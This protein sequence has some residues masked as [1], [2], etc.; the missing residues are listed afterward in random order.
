MAD[1]RISVLVKFPPALLARVAAHAEK[2]KA[3][4]MAAILALIERGLDGGAPEP[5]PQPSPAPASPRGPT[6][7]A[8]AKQRSAKTVAAPER[9]G[10]RRLVG[11]DAAT[12]DPIYR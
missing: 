10:V 6:T 4:R 2:T 9:A 1:D 8:T 7:V 12:G 5:V 11:Y 3:P